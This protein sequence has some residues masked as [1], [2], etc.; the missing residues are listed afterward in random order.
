MSPGGRRDA[1]GMSSLPFEPLLC[2]IDHLLGHDRECP[3]PA[4]PF[5]EA[6]K[7]L[8][9]GRCIFDQVDLSGRTELAGWLAELRDA[10]STGDYGVSD[11]AR[12]RFY[13][14]L[15]AGRSD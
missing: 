7:G 3:G 10:I 14:R 1:T 15:N 8:A 2:R 11:E 4:C 5:W 9:A 13:E 12:R 6:G